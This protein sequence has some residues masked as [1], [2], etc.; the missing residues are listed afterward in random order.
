MTIHRYVPDVD[1]AVARAKGA[2]ATVTMEPEDMFWGERY[3]TITD[4]F[5]HHWSF[6]A[7]VRELSEEEMAEAAQK[8]FS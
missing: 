8:A 1:V 4:P 3:A 5:G 7:V 2:G 6:S